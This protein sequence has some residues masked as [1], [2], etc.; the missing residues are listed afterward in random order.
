MGLLKKLKNAALASTIVVSLMGCDTYG[1]NVIQNTEQQKQN[2]LS[3]SDSLGLLQEPLIKIADEREKEYYDKIKGTYVDEKKKYEKRPEYPEG[4][5]VSYENVVYV[6]KKNLDKRF[7]E[8]FF[9]DLQ[10][11]NL[12][13]FYFM[14]TKQDYDLFVRRGFRGKYG[15]DIE[16]AYLKDTYEE[17]KNL[18]TRGFVDALKEFAL[19]R[20]MSNFLAEYTFGM[21]EIKYAGNP[22]SSIPQIPV[23]DEFQDKIENPHKYKEEHI[24]DQFWLKENLKNIKFSIDFTTKFMNLDKDEGVPGVFPRISMRVA[25]LLR[26]QANTEKKEIQTSLGLSKGDFGLG[27]A[28]TTDYDMWKQKDIAIRTSYLFPEFDKKAIIR[29][30][31]TY[32]FKTPNQK[33]EWAVSV[34]FFWKF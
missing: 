10:N 16:K 22:K 1:Y 21:L 18:G 3:F 19:Y 17:A 20:K 34:D 9:V 28:T 4:Y 33:E 7:G 8:R 25:D 14:A 31:F 27:I 2:T 5:A 13:N 15:D 12:R 30:G 24:E 23:V 6:L 26:I 29:P 11:S 32:L